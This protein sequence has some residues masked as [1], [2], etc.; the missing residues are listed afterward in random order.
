ML[1]RGF[2]MRDLQS[3]DALC[4]R[5][6]LVAILQDGAYA[7]SVQ[8]ADFCDMLRDA[9]LATQTV[10]YR[11]LD[12]RRF[13]NGSLQVTA[14][15]QTLDPWGR[16]STIYHRFRFDQEQTAYVIREFGAT[17]ISY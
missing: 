3:I 8:A 2:E 9:A 6:G 5:N 7:Y 11:I 17:T 16:P 4:P 12:V 15:H 13:I 10:G 1:I 14:E